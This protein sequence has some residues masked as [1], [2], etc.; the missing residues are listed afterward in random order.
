MDDS[1]RQYLIPL[2]QAIRELREQRGV[3][4][5]DL[6]AAAGVDLK[7]V[8]ALENGRL[9]P[10][11]QLLVRLAQ[12]MDVRTSAFFVR[13]EQLGRPDEGTGSV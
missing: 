12:A 5:G 8:D 6:A 10:N 4:A 13:A 3:D 1:R 9:D 2:G 11:F 7:R